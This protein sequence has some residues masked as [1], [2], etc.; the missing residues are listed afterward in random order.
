MIFSFYLKIIKQVP[1]HNHENTIFQPVHCP[2]NLLNPNI[3]IQFLLSRPHTFIIA[4]VGRSCKN[5]RESILG[6]NTL[7]SHDL[8]DGLS[9]DISR[10]NFILIHY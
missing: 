3:K 8:S 6:D 4:V 7:N 9:I 1:G 10:R 5:S 2:F